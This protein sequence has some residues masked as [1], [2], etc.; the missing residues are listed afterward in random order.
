MAPSYAASVHGGVWGDGAYATGG[1]EGGGGGGDGGQCLE[2]GTYGTNFGL[3]ST[4]VR[5]QVSGPN[6]QFFCTY[7]GGV[8]EGQP[9]GSAWN[10]GGEDEE[11]AVRDVDE[12]MD[13]WT[14]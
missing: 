5:R 1:G 14:R 10:E 4:L 8:V 2:D 12:N 7:E 3:Q 11:R 13:T 9:P 6:P